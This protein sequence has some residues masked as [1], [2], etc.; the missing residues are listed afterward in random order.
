M[1]EIGLLPLLALVE[2]T[3]LG[4]VV[5]VGLGVYM[6]AVRSRARA[7]AQALVKRV[8]EDAE[9]REQETRKLLSERFALQGEDLENL[10]SRIGREEKLFYQNQITTF[11]R[12]DGE[13]FANLLVDT[14]ALV[15]PYRELPEQSAAPAADAVTPEQGAGGADPAELGRLQDENKRLSDE[16]RITMETMGRMLNEYSSMF[17]GGAAAGMDKEK[18]MEMFRAEAT[19]AVAAETGET[20]AP[21]PVA[22]DDIQVE[23]PATESQP[24]EE[25]S[26]EPADDGAGDETV[27][28]QPDEVAGIDQ[29]I[30]D[31]L[32]E[33]AGEVDQSV[34]DDLE[35]LNAEPEPND[36]IELEVGD[37]L[38]VLEE[39][40][41]ED[42]IE[43]NESSE[44]ALGDPEDW[45][46]DDD[47]ASQA[48]VPDSELEAEPGKKK[49]E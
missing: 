26:E 17:A 41:Q 39:A 23:T 36:D 10:V 30:A 40:G 11:L 37:D 32:A 48:V 44:E 4:I 15:Q 13:A 3:L 45:F 9:R 24:A 7:G 27:V 2:L 25:A 43:A 49:P 20:P 18:M 42:G 34:E 47:G 31:A 6:L 16:L 14:E 35:V 38:E 21:A 46:G 1:I 28:L 33:S 29:D 12:R 5:A 19:E 8:K 22:T